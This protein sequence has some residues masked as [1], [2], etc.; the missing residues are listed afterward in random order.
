MARN[1]RRSESS[2]VAAGAGLGV[3]GLGEDNNGDKMRI[4]RRLDRVETALRATEEGFRCLCKPENLYVT[5]RNE[6][7]ERPIG[8]VEKCGKCGGRRRVMIIQVR[9]DRETWADSPTESSSEE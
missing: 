4:G 7:D 8:A 6:G 5:Y 9:R 2:G 1:I 3:V